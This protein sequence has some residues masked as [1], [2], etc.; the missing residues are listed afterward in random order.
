MEGLNSFT[1]IDDGCAHGIKEG[2]ALND[3]VKAN[4]RPFSSFGIM[5]ALYATSY[6]A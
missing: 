4:W 5:I 2:E 6:I 3:K 1:A